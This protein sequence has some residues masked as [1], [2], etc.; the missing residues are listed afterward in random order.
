M[1]W[2]KQ[3]GPPCPAPEHHSGEK[4]VPGW[5]VWSLALWSD[6]EA[7]LLFPLFDTFVEIQGRGW[8]VWGVWQCWWELMKAWSPLPSDGAEGLVH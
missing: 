6:K 4:A 7:S 8:L 5:T 2:Q 1:A 3:Q